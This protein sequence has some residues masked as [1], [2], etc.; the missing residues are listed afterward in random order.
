MAPGDAPTECALDVAYAKHVESYTTGRRW[1]A[2]ARTALEATGVIDLVLAD[3]PRQGLWNA[4][5]EPGSVAATADLPALQQQCKL[6]LVIAA[7]ALLFIGMLSEKRADMHRLT[8]AIAALCLAAQVCGA[9][10]SWQALSF[11]PFVLAGLFL[12][13]PKPPPPAP[14]AP[15][16]APATT[17]TKQ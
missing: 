7:I 17:T 5:A 13:R 10:A 11:G 8:A 9:S 12:G 15:A 2:S 6:V 3:W 14:A 1:V 16:Q 4:L